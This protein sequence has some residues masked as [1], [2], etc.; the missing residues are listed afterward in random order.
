MIY[1]LK[2]DK[3]EIKVSTLGAELQSIKGADGFE[4]LWQGDPQY[5]DGRSPILFPI[6]GGLPGGKYSWKGVTYEMGSHGFAR[7]SEFDLAKQT[8]DT[9]ELKLS[10]SE[11]TR[12]QYPFAFDFYV[13]YTVR[14]NTV[15]E[16]FRVVNKNAETM[17]FSVGGHPAFNC[18]MDEGKDYGDYTIT[19]EKTETAV[20]YIKADKALTGE[21]LPFLENESKKQL[22]HEWFKR[23]AVILK[24]I[25]S[26]WAE[27]SAG[28]RSVRVDFAGFPDFGIWSCVND[29]PYVC[30]EPW[31]GIDS[32]HT[33]SGKLEEKY[34]I[35]FL[36]A[37]E[38]FE[39][40]FTMTLKA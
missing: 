8:E 26:H 21:T 17:P 28:G 11:E 35:Q 5:W 19:F 9:L 27:L 3:L 14:G 37:G 4:Y 39:A 6:V 24:G 22:S 31:Y 25:Q 38:T 7:K 33:D 16:G 15:S 18:P 2:S 10:D 20:R 30:L 29:G 23:D 32:F 36:P 34:G 1:S 13:I 12:K 40:A